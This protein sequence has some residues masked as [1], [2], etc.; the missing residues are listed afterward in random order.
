MNDL[1]EII[2]FFL[3]ISA[4]GLNMFLPAALLTR[5]SNLPNGRA[6]SGRGGGHPRFPHINLQ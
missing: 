6:F 4:V 1:L 3:V 2:V 5:I